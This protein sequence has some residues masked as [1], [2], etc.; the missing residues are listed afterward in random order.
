MKIAVIMGGVSKEHDIS[1][2]TGRNV[3]EALLQKGHSVFPVIIQK[4]GGWLGCG[5]FI[6]DTEELASLILSNEKGVFPEEMVLLIRKYQ[7]DVVFPALHGPFGEDGRI[8]GFFEI[9]GIPY[10]GSNHVGSVLSNDKIVTKIL[11][12]QYSLPTARWIEITSPDYDRILKNFQFPLVLKAPS[13]GS[14][15]GLKIIR[16]ESQLKDSLMTL[17][18]LEGRLLVE[19]FHGGKEIT[20]GVLEYADGKSIA[21]PP[22]EIIPRVSEY[23]DFDA[24]Y[25]E[26]GSEE[27]TPARISPED[28]ISIQNLAVK[29]HQVLRMKGLSRTDF[30][31]SEG[32]AIILE[33]NS[34]PGFTKTS[35]F[36]QAAK[37]AGLSFGEL[38]EH[39]VTTVTAQS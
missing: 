18:N 36:P 3:A 32:K 9:L 6:D 16:K 39:L 20:C 29:S 2:K 31:L 23:F 1:I 22:T 5:G 30:I 25:K 17:L 11:L 7:I 4:D 14:S 12:D 8:Q 21:L 10:V 37:V 33:S 19:Q 24:K 27:I 38:V 28:T 26:G 35:L 15:F 34:I 13:E